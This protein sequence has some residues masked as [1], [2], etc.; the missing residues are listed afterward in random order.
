[1]NGFWKPAA[2]R[3]RCSMS[4]KA[5]N[6]NKTLAGGPGFEPG[7]TESESAVLP[8][9]YPPPL[10]G[11]VLRRWILELAQERCVV[12]R[13]KPVNVRLHVTLLRSGGGNGVRQLPG[14]TGRS[15]C[16]PAEHIVPS[17]GR[18]ATSDGRARGAHPGRSPQTILLRGTRHLVQWQPPNGGKRLSQ[19]AEG[20][21]RLL[22]R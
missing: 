2:N 1:V 13:T 8:L 6:S 4:G 11:D 5:E 17:S 15:H 21:R 22:P 9:N 16:Y 19:R 3:S 12:G 7:L 20:A 10:G 18:V 14:V